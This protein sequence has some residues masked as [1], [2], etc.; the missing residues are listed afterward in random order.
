[1][2]TGTEAKPMRADARRNYERLVA[3]A[4]DAFAE[5]GADA[6]L[7]DIAR[8]ASVGPGTLYRH[9]P[10][11]D[12]LLAAV[13]GDWVEEVRAE[14]ESGLADTDDPAGAL[15][16]WLRRLLRH[17]TT[18]NGL[19]AAIVASSRDPHSALAT[20]CQPMHSTGRAL[21]ERAQRAGA[22]RADVTAADIHR[23]VHAIAMATE[24]L[25]DRH[26]TAARML[27]I[28]LAGLRTST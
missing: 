24:S 11:R 21:V 13:L 1:M 15:D 19:A 4:R 8:R 10:N 18:Y 6:S 27:S 26:A 3:V 22:V 25:P 5:H 20:A 14:A 12:A 23:L 2:A 9:F 17:V 28:A 7:D 16:R